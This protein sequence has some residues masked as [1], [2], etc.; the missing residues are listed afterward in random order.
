MPILLILIV[1]I[2]TTHSQEVTVLFNQGF[3]S[4]ISFTDLGFQ[5]SSLNSQF[6]PTISSNNPFSGSFSLNIEYIPEGLGAYSYAINEFS[7]PINQS[8]M[9]DFSFSFS[10][11]QYQSLPLTG[12]IGLLFDGPE[13]LFA[14]MYGH[15]DNPLWIRDDN[16]GFAIYYLSTPFTHNEWDTYN[17]SLITDLDEALS[18]GASTGFTVYPTQLSGL[19]FYYDAEI[20]LQNDWDDIDIKLGQ[21]PSS[22][23]A[24]TQPTSTTTGGNTTRPGLNITTFFFNSDGS[25]NPYIILLP[26]IVLISSVALVRF[27]YRSRSSKSG[28]TRASLAPLRNRIDFVI[29]KLSIDNQSSKSVKKLEMQVSQPKIGKRIH[30]SFSHTVKEE[31]E[32]G[33]IL[34]Q[35][36]KNERFTA[37]FGVIQVIGSPKVDLNY[38]VGRKSIV[39]HLEYSMD[40]IT[41]EGV[42]TDF[43]KTLAVFS[44]FRILDSFEFTL[45]FLQDI[46][47][48][49][50][51]DQLKESIVKKLLKTWKYHSIVVPANYPYPITINPGMGNK[52]VS[53]TSENQEFTE[54]K[55]IVIDTEAE[56]QIINFVEVGLAKVAAK[57]VIQ[58]PDQLIEF[59]SD[60]GII[61]IKDIYFWWIDKLGMELQDLFSSL[62]KQ[63]EET[64]LTD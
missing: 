48:E 52:F 37:T 10:T 58:S 22:T 3:E 16:I 46:V 30:A 25:I 14:L 43:D 28:K 18:S 62:S 12:K 6:S 49:A 9:T 4:G 57:G 2:P 60:Q 38:K 1:F 5:I 17:R 21:R 45:N 34:K 32:A 13:G 42:E 51:S 56:Q 20:E 47:K 63:L 33:Y 24:S 39:Q 23:Q 44:A 29:Y 7:V 55:E 50:F 61:E 64:S 35:I 40:S 41:E 11:F 36:E 27:N 59:S 15:Y 19:L 26:P 54:R 8:L 31:K 53:L